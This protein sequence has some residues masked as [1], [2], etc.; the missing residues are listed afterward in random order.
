MK[1]MKITDVFLLVLSLSGTVSA[2]PDLVFLDSAT[3]PQVLDAG[4]PNQQLHA[5]CTVKNQGTTSSP[6]FL[7]SYAQ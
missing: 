1:T 4:C 6:R 7:W 2:K 5:T 3:N